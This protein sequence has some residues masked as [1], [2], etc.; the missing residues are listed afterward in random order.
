ML[1]GEV[2]VVGATDV[3]GLV[4]AVVVLTL[5]TG[6]LLVLV[7]EEAVVDVVVDA[8]VAPPALVVA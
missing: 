4:E 6:D 7:A 5:P 2:V 1:A 3:V 8:L